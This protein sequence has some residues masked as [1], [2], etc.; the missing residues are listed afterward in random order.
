MAKS[1]PK[2]NSAWLVEFAILGWQWERSILVVETLAVLLH[3]R[4][5][6]IGQ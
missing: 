4:I 3:G 6:V 5:G 2:H 1:R